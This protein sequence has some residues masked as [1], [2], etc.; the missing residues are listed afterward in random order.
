MTL[1]P[2]TRTRAPAAAWCVALTCVSVASQLREH[3]RRQQPGVS[4]WHVCLLRHSYE[5][6]G[7]G[8]SL[9]C[10]IYD[11][12]CTDNDWIVD[13]DDMTSG[14]P[15][16]T[17]VVGDTINNQN[18][19]NNRCK[20]SPASSYMYSSHWNIFVDVRLQC[21]PAY[22]RWIFRQIYLVRMDEFSLNGKRLFTLA[23]VAL[24]NNCYNARI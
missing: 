21:C 5:N 10:R 15:S 17:F 2:A 6:T 24:T 23:G 8:S 16:C 14:T 12:G 9:V 20:S 19:T 1:F 22:L 3:G 7:A 18:T 13:A 4:H 11:S